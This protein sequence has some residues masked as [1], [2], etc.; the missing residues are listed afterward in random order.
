MSNTPEASSGDRPVIRSVQMP[1]GP[2]TI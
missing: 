1:P 2:A